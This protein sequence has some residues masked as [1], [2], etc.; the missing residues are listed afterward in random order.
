MVDDMYEINSDNIPPDLKYDENIILWRYMSFSSL[1]E[2][3]MYNYIPLIR[4]DL[5]EDKSE[6]I[7]FKEI[8]K[9]IIQIQQD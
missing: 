9:K 7:I 4:S 5:F 1:C 6:G 3:L 2:I 8:I